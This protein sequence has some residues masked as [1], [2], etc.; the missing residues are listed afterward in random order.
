[1]NEYVEDNNSFKK[2]FEKRYK[3]I[4]EPAG[5]KK[6]ESQKWCKANQHKPSD[7]LRQ[8]NQETESRWTAQ[9]LQNA[10]RFNEI[11]IW[12][13]K[14]YDYLRYYEEK[15]DVESEEE[16]EEIEIEAVD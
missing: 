12:K 4:S 1:V 7:I 6:D 11:K 9:M 16:G 8:F 2:W 3:K 14:G 10:L 5:L 15:E 13:S